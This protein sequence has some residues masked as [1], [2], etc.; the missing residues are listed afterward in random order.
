[1]SVNE[2]DGLPLNYVVRAPPT[3]SIAKGL[4]HVRRVY[5]HQAVMR[6]LNLAIGDVVV[7]KHESAEPADQDDDIGIAFGI[8]WPTNVVDVHT[9]QLHAMLRQSHL[10]YEGDRVRLSKFTGKTRYTK[11]ISVCCIE[12][13]RP[14]ASE[15]SL[16]ASALREL[17]PEIRY[18]TE[19]MEFECQLGS[20]V[21]AF[22]VVGI[23]E[24]E[25]ADREASGLDE[26]K[27]NEKL[28]SLS[29]SLRPSIKVST[30]DSSSSTS[31]SE[32]DHELPNLYVF[33]ESTTVRIDHRPESNGARMFSS[34][35]SSPR[36]SPRNA[37]FGDNHSSAR[38]SS[39][40]TK[41]KFRTASM[42]A[43][44]LPKKDP[45]RNKTPR[46]TPIKSNQANGNM[47][48]APRDTKPRIVEIDTD[49]E[50]SIRKEA[51]MAPI[52][53]SSIGGLAAQISSLR[54]IVELPLLKP[55]VFARFNMSPPRGVL[56]YGPP[57]TGKTMLL[58]AVAHETSAH[59]FTISGPSIISKYMG[60][61]EEN[62][63]NLWQ[64]AEKAGPSII[65]IDEVDAITPKR[66]ADSGEAESRIVASLLTLMDGM[67]V[68]S[69]VVVIA[70]TNRPNT[71]D[72]ALRRP[73]RFDREI[74][75]GI[76]DAKARLEILEVLLEKIPHELSL[77]FIENIA[78]KTHGFVGADLSAVCR[79]SVL[80]T[81]KAGLKSGKSEKSLVVEESHM[82]EALPLVR[83]SAMREI[84]LETPKTR[85]S[86]IG[87]QESVKQKLRESVEWPLKHPETFKRL[88]IIPA[89]GVLLYGPPGCS[90]TLTAKALATE[91]GLNF[92]AV[93]GPEIFNKYIGE[94]ERALRE[95]FRKARAASPSIIFFDEID[96]LSS[97]R[98]SEGE[99][100]SDRILTTLL[101][102]I[103]GVEDLINVTILAATN[104]PD[105]IDSALLR[106]GRL[107]K[108]LYVGP[109]DLSSREKILEIQFNKMS[110]S[111]DLSIP[112][113]AVALDGCSG[114]EIAGVCRDAGLLAMHDNLEAL[115]IDKRHFEEAVGKVKRG[116]TPEMIAFYEA[117]A[118]IGA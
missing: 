72:P 44:P 99:G 75:I 91:A 43:A 73:G 67:D 10:I 97:S 114:A 1:M 61:A 32:E 108:L 27:L 93:K 42:S 80:V 47:S 87:G 81:I 41:D 31:D 46:D 38:V 54:E 64:K 36:G 12:E 69:K 3:T 102:E 71:I 20:K 105:V 52:T 86:D 98:G 112:D 113:L 34:P 15:D 60:E 13:N 104:R 29:M 115:Q 17:L 16:W 56:L 78:S 11:E 63:R 21:C 18:V 88:G 116:I 35:R 8:A 103:D 19:G 59:V 66:E 100:A 49:E 118:E 33:R 85:W 55:H 107:D 65:F 9:V 28:E 89:K 50:E 51:N 76:P 23:V 110:I 7:I 79:E 53:Y 5:L 84:F 106:P 94:A 25:H 45:A 109:P 48:L 111:S 37:N 26:H 96:A 22:T 95:V 68:N 82:L 57:G 14:A 6:G 4:R 58:R 117:F 101:N 90:K 83:P 2:G 92:M 77:S 24:D 39:P 70:A 74:E 40:L 30:T 62:L